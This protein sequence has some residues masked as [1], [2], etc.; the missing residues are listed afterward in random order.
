MPAFMSPESQ[1]TKSSGP[2]T[3]TSLMSPKHG[4]VGEHT[5]ERLP[6]VVVDG[7]AIPCLHLSN[8]INGDEA[9]QIIHGFSSPLR[10]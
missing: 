1:R 2:F 6:V 5:A 8:F 7:G 9:L 3:F 10:G 4:V